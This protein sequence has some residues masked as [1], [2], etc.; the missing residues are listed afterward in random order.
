MET[1][2][3]ESDLFDLDDLFSIACAMEVLA[4]A[5]VALDG[6]SS[7]VDDCFMEFVLQIVEVLTNLP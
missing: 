1:L 3:L 5:N 6:L 7:E 2:V 4:G